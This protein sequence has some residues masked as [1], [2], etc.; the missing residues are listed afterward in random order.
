MFLE[1]ALLYESY[2]LFLCA[3]GRALEADK[4]YGIGISRLESIVFFLRVQLQNDGYHVDVMA[5]YSLWFNQ[6][7]RAP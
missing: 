5:N 6:K 7:S 4:V 3:Q 2:A 1:D